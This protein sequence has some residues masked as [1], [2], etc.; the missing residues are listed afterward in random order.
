MGIRAGSYT[1]N[2]VAD[3]NS[4]VS[5][6]VARLYKVCL[7]RQYEQDGL[8]NWVNGLL[9]KRLTGSSAAR[10]FFNS[11]EF[12]NR[13]LN[14][15]DFVTVAYRTLLNREPDNDGLDSWVAALENKSSRADV[16]NG[17]TK[18]VEFG[19]LCAEYGITR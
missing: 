1:S 3:I 18:S 17:F 11:D 16:V 12:K 7:G 15:R 6:F 8:N 14:D 10:G 19:N 5:A 4:K 2:E 13:K 9:S